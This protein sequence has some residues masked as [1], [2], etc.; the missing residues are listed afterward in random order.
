MVP[1]VLVKQSGLGNPKIAPS[2]KGQFLNPDQGCRIMQEKT[3]RNLFQSIEV[4][5]KPVRTLA[6][7]I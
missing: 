4:M 7:V 6:N 5:L 3:T 2:Q 1:L